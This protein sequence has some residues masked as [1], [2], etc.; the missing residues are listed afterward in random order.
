MYP[1]I[2]ILSLGLSCLLGACVSKKKYRAIKTQQDA[3]ALQLDSTRHQLAEALRHRKKNEVETSATTSDLSNRI[4]NLERENQQIKPALAAAQQQILLLEDSMLQT[5]KAFDLIQQEWGAVA[6]AKAIAE[7]K[8]RALQ[9]LLS[10]SL[11]IWDSLGLEIVQV[12]DFVCLDISHQLLF[13]RGYYFTAQGKKFLRQL[14]PLLENQREFRV[15]VQ[16]A[17]KGSPGGSTIEASSKRAA[18]VAKFLNNIGLSTER[19][20]AQGMGLWRNIQKKEQP[21]ISIVLIPL[22][23]PAYREF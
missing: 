5:Q 4:Q 23:N 9:S 15:V 7:T 2:L 18:T 20:I 21:P 8:A 16:A 17:V 19:I 6:Q 3:L 1:Y 10:D 11:E 12:E 14:V 13:G 22:R